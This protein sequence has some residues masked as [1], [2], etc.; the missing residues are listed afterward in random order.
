[1][2]QLNGDGWPAGYDPPEPL[3]KVTFVPSWRSGHCYA[4]DVLPIEEA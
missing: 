4:I 3:M 2:Y 1:M